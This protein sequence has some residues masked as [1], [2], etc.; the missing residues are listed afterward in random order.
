MTIQ[1]A[2]SIKSI[3]KSYKLYQS[4]YDI[5]KEFINPFGRKYHKKFDALNNISFDVEKGEVVGIIGKNGSGKSTLLKILNS[6]VSPS[7]GSFECKGRISAL[8]ELGGGFNM[9][10]TG[11]ENVVY[12]GAIQG[13]SKK[14]MKT[15]LSQI[16]DFAEIGE[17]ANQPVHTYSSG[18]YVRL[19]FSIAIHID[20]E[21]LIVDEALSVGDIR[22][23]K[24]CYRK[25]RSIKDAGKTILLCTHSTS[26]VKE[27]CTKAIWLH[28]GIIKE[29]GDPLFVIDQYQAFML[30]QN[31]EANANQLVSNAFKLSSPDYISLKTQ[32]PN[33]VW[34]RI[35]NCDQ[36]GTRQVEILSAVLTDPKTNKNIH[37]IIGGEL[38]KLILWVYAKEDVIKPE[39]RI[40]LDGQFNNSIFK[41][42]NK[43]YAQ[44]IILKS[45]INQLIAIDFEFPHIGNGSYSLSFGVLSMFDN[46]ELQLHWVHNGIFLEV[47]N[48]NIIYQS[49]SQIILKNAKFSVI[50][51]K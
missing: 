26:V 27:F 1:P 21:I 22:F 4:R 8:L 28:D 38:L 34:Q 30:S 43:L 51:Q 13:F 11:I 19:A 46:N 9:E 48:P 41:L 40:T 44:P 29:Q 12:L 7:S 35:D 50:N 36:Y 23:Q 20:P 6:V 25:I 2:I 3:S 5:I 31:I 37:Q 17:Y 10:L 49:G 33:L 45:G 47:T 18:M 39:I 14:E 42:S 16:L 24:K 15:R 32:F